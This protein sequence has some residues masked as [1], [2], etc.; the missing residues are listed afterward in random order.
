MLNIG[1]IGLL[2][3]LL[4]SNPRH[5]C[6]VAESASRYCEDLIL[7]DPAK[8]DKERKV[9]NCRGPMRRIQERLYRTL[10]APNHRPSYHSHGGVPGRSIK[11]NV[12]PHRGSKFVYTTDIADFYPSVHHTRVYHLFVERFGCSPD[13]ARVCTKLCTYRHHLAQ[14]LITS[15]IL[16]DCLLSTSDK[17]IARMC[18]NDGIVYTRYVDDITLSATYPIESGSY[19]KLVVRILKASGFDVNVSKEDKGRLSEGK[20]ITKLRLRR[21]KLDVRPAYLAEIRSQLED[22]ATLARGG[23]CVGTYHTSGQILGRIQFI[24]WINPGRRREL[25]RLYRA[26]SWQNV[27]NEALRCGLVALRK[28]AVKPPGVAVN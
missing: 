20:S 24:A 18:E 3:R 7:I 23:E 16:A 12:E 13:V 9:V 5:L 14:G 26:V 22:A 17:R 10:L 27:E 19:P 25:M 11:T 4:G 8:P 1:G 2:A 6:A 28:R 15:P 21:G